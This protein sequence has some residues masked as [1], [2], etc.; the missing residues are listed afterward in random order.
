MF[1]LSKITDAIGGLLSGSQT[2]TPQEGSGITEL[3][4]NAGIDPTLLDGLSQ[5]EIMNLL[6]QYGIDPS[7]LDLGQVSELL[8]K[9]KVGSNV[10][11][12]AQNWLN[13]RGN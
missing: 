10:A 3:L 12:M 13:S 1:D 7:Q 5:D 8:Q 2:Q 11:E 6:Q 4:G 9:S